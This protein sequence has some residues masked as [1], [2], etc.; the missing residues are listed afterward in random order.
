MTK[1]CVCVCVYVSE[2]ECLYCVCVMYVYTHTFTGLQLVK[3]LFCIGYGMSQ[4]HTRYAA[5]NLCLPSHDLWSELLTQQPGPNLTA[6]ASSRLSQ[7]GGYPGTPYMI[8]QL[9]MNDSS[10]IDITIWYDMG[11][12]TAIGMFTNWEYQ[13]GTGGCDHDQWPMTYGDIWHMTHD[14]PWPTGMSPI[15]INIA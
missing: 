6:L 13:S 10:R 12:P 3:P 15:S 4:P 5:V 2:C 11:S 7:V 8:N 9:G 1:S 14:Q